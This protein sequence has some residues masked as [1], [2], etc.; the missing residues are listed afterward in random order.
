[1]PGTPMLRFGLRRSLVVSFALTLVLLAPAAGSGSPAG[2]ATPGRGP[3]PAVWPG[4]GGP[5]VPARPQAGLE[6]QVTA[7]GAGLRGATVKLP[8]ASSR[9]RRPTPPAASDSAGC[10]AWGRTTCCT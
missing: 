9:R 3:A 8:R 1:M 6:G 7:D 10:A 4:K 2:R 5:T